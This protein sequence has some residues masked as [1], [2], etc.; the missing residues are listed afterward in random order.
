MKGKEV[1]QAEEILERNS[2]VRELE[3]SI[4][5]CNRDLEHARRREVNVKG[6]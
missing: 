2:A 6:G 3:E 5:N 4:G 1:L